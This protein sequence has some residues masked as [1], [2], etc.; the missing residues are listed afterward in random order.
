MENGLGSGVNEPDEGK[1]TTGSPVTVTQ[2]T[3]AILCTG[4]DSISDDAV[5][6]G[7]NAMH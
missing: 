1:F 6:Q 7:G 5:N 4:R 3:G 2:S